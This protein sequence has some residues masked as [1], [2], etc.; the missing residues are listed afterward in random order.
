MT[1]PGNLE[2][3]LV[4]RYVDSLSSQRVGSYFNLDARLGWHPNRNL[5]IAVVGQNLL[6]DHHPEFGGGSGGFTEVE[7]S[8]YGKMTWRW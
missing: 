2:F 5:E 6:E 1:L 3:D 4:W 8:V 7:R